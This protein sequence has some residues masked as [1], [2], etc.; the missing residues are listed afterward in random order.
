MDTFGY[1]G[2][3]STFTLGVF[4]L[5]SRI[6]YLKTPWINAGFI[7]LKYPVL[8]GVF[9]SGYSRSGS[10]VIAQPLACTLPALPAAS[11]HD[12][13]SGELCSISGIS[14]PDA[15]HVL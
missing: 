8:H 12:V 10:P 14:H 13:H 9:S 15:R 7:Q 2:V 5:S 1:D 3:N 4:V 6:H 11:V